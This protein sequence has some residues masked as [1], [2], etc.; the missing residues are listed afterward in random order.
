MLII[1]EHIYCNLRTKDVVKCN[2][3][4]LFNY[5]K[6]YEKN[7]WKNAMKNYFHIST[8][9]TAQRCGRQESV[10]VYG[11]IQDIF[12]LLSQH[13]ARLLAGSIIFLHNNKIKMNLNGISTH[14]HTTIYN[15]KLLFINRNIN[16]IY[17][18]K[19]EFT[20]EEQNL[21]ALLSRQLTY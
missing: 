12:L 17:T 5:I 4:V 13:V 14:L 8:M 3:K 15:F 6:L 19:Q 10:Q 7:S 20:H 1:K 21:Q 2:P 18:R 9:K 11:L 16:L